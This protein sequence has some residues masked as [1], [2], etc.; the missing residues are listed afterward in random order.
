MD[1]AAAGQR[2]SIDALTMQ[3]CRAIASKRTMERIGKLEEIVGH[4]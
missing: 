3:K 1:V 2:V 4:L